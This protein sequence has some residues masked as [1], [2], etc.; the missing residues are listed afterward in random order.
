MKENAQ[1]ISTRKL[2]GAK[3]MGCGCGG[4]VKELLEIACFAMDC[5]SLN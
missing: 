2:Q 1:P 5:G 3:K 4:A